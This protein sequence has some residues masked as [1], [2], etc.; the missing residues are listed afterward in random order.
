[1]KKV[2]VV[3]GGMAGLAAAYYLDRGARESGKALEVSLFEASDRLGG[4]VRSLS[5]GPYRLEGGPDAVVRYKPWFL[6]LVR[7]L[8]LED[9]I[10]G[11]QPAKPA[12]LIH[13]GGRGHPLPEGLNVVI[14]SRF[15]PLLTTPL[16]SPIGK[17]RAGLDLF[18][19]RGPEGD[20]PFGAFIERRLGREVWR[21][22]AAPL[23]GGIYGGD[24]YE[25][26]TLAAFPMLKELERQ[27]RSLVLGS[28]ATMRRRKGSREGGGLF[29]SLSG[30]LG[31]VALAVQKQ[32]T[33]VRWRMR[34]PV[35]RA[36]REEQGWYL[37]GPWGTERFDAVVFATPAPAAATALEPLD[38]E[39]AR[40][41]RSIPYG[42]AATVTFALEE[43][44][45]PPLKG[46]GV[47]IA[48]GE[49]FAAR[50]FT[51]LSRKWANRAPAGKLLVRAYF[52][53][54]PADL[55]EDAL[56]EAA[57]DDLKRLL[58]F[59]P[60]PLKTW[61]FRWP[62]GMPQYTVGHLERIRAL[63]EASKRWPGLELIGAAYRGVGLPEVVRD[64]RQAAE[65]LLA[66][67]A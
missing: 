31:E 28:L 33:G 53:G 26:S 16:L 52:S 11:T 56:I 24:P 7:E 2:A 36:D 57:R 61:A 32:A 22:L 19:P 30:G 45:V 5:D 40:T 3:G 18:L 48:A 49:G 17:L 1:M 63:E 13:K 64:G 20:E 6:Q 12:A 14:P 60:Q 59:E 39:L 29:A 25:L 37:F 42:S 55:D 62:R 8:G 47:L 4:K 65:R 43:E 21:N 35:E 27:H 44:A 54:E 51:W 34:S 23:T 10:V 38:R 46:H 50:G 15:G 9:R 67:L 66:S 58:A 41:L